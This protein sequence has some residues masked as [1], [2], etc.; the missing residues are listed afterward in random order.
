MSLYEKL[1]K[2][3]NI[4]YL[5]IG[6]SIGEGTGVINKLDSWS[7]VLNG[8]LTNKYKSAVFPY[9]LTKGSSTTYDGLIELTKE[10]FQQEFDL[11]FICIG[12]ND[13][14]Q[15]NQTQFKEH[16]EILIRQLINKYPNVE[17]VTILESSLRMK[18]YE[19]AILDLSSHYKLLNIN[20]I[21]AFEKT[22][23]NYV[24]LAPDGTHPNER[25]QKN[26]AKVI[27]ETISE[28]LKNRKIPDRLKI[29][30]LYV[31]KDNKYILKDNSDPTFFNGFKKQD[32][33]FLSGKNRDS[34]KY[35]FKGEKLVLTFES[36]A[37]SG[38]VRVLIDGKF[39]KE[40][41]T[42]SPWTVNRHYLI[43]SD[44]K[45]KN[46]QVEIINIEESSEKQNLK[47]ISIIY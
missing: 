35:T 15:L 11:I 12:Q 34:I 43:T 46:H 27:E 45:L 38:M 8:E 17:I 19:N 23:V 13:Q 4:R 24:K 21:E 37:H 25:G 10:N 32:G 31:K 40:I 28:N 36:N 7:E 5:I 44:L 16:Y 18:E 3:K 47:L 14:L 29:K 20:T 30:P 41:N 2:E 22:G 26:Y 39:E 1:Q 6:D 42:N 9:K 33:Y